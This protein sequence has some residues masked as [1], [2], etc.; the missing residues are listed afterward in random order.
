VPQLASAQAAETAAS[1][2]VADRRPPLSR[3][4]FFTFTGTAVTASLLMKLTDRQRSVSYPAAQRA[5]DGDPAHDAPAGRNSGSAAVSAIVSPVSA[6]VSPVV[7]SIAA[8]AD[9]VCHDRH[10]GDRSGCPGHRCGSDHSGA[11]HASSG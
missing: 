2:V 8:A 11:A 7:A 9:T 4:V 1:S 5:T 10:S 6:V 3:Q